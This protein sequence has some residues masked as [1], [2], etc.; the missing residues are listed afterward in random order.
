VLSNVIRLNGYDLRIV[1]NTLKSTTHNRN[2]SNHSYILVT[3]PQ[4]IVQP[5]REVELDGFEPSELVGTSHFS[6]Q[7]AKEQQPITDLY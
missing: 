2:N 6:Q 7:V 1:I 4:Q 5:W 3:T